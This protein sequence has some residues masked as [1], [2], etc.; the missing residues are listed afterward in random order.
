M[1]PPLIA[2]S[3]LQDFREWF[4]AAVPVVTYHKLGPRPGRVRIKGL[5][6]SNGLFRRQL[7]EWSEAGFR[8]GSIAEVG[9]TD[10]NPGKKV[11]LTFDD[12]FENVLRHGLEPMRSRG[13]TAIQFLVADLIGKSNEWEQ[14]EGETRE[15]LMD[16][17]QVREWLA[18][19][20]EIG[21]HSCTH[22]HLTQIPLAQAREEIFSSRRKL[23]D[24]FGIPIRH[25]CYP[26]GDWNPAVRDLVAGAGYETAV[27]TEA[28]ANPAGSDRLA[29]KRF[30]VRYA[31]RNWGNFG[32]VLRHWLG[33]F[34]G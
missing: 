1:T 17:G 16:A 23:E 33:R 3:S 32:R 6:V 27:T 11:V 26:Y 25:F 24:V 18:A 4:A 7:E 13:F 2:Y 28:G 21:A 14:R 22:P 5:Y 31:S 19:G 10:G 9:K 12:G 30:T 8:S 29:L 15:A 34:R 20:N